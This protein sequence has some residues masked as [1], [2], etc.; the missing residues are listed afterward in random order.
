MSISYKWKSYT[1][2]AY[3]HTKWD[4]NKYDNTYFGE[5]GVSIK[6][7]KVYLNIV[8]G[9][10][11]YH[12][13]DINPTK[14]GEITK[15]YCCGELQSQEE[16]T[17]GTF[18]WKV[19]MPSGK[20]LWPAV[21]LCGKY[22]WPPEIDVFEGYTDNKGSYLDCLEVNY[23]TNVHYATK[24]SPHLQC[25]ARGINRLIYTLLNK[26]ENEWKLVWTPSYIKIY[27]NGF[28][29][30][31]IKDSKVLKHI[32]QNPKM[33]IIMNMMSNSSQVSLNQAPLIIHDFK[34]MPA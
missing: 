18:I 19:T 4:S 20:Y 23:C 14:D 29:I 26:K 30:R 12:K 8:K 32:N 25:K 1:W 27:W 3:D 24:T 34:Y 11:S 13:G 10:S 21:W 33:Y 5:A 22:S 17:Y 7:D 15:H 6:E 31:C 16:F 28:R 2:W 9:Q